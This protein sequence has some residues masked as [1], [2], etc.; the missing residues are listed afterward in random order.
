MMA[1]FFSVIVPTRNRPKEFSKALHSILEQTFE[2]YEVVVV[3]DGTSREHQ[4]E[5]NRVELAS[6][7][8]VS[9]LHLLE[10]KN[11]HGHCYGR[12]HGVSHAR[13]EYICFLDDDDLWTDKEYLGRAY[14][15][16]KKEGADLYLAN[17][18]SSSKD[19]TR[20]E[21][22]CLNYLS[23]ALNLDKASSPLF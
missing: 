19:G 7:E 3:N 17:Q 21:F 23:N 15:Y 9:F 8:K 18:Q 2:D 14:E 20:V 12:N 22:L 16:I 5:Y 4:P 6:G 11:G 10:R 13:G 1:P